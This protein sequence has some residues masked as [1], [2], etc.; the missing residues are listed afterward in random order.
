LIAIWDL[1]R[2]QYL[3]IPCPYRIRC[4]NVFHDFV[5]QH[6]QH[7]R[8]GDYA[9]D[10]YAKDTN[11]FTASMGWR[12]DL[13]YVPLGSARSVSYSQNMSKRMSLYLRGLIFLVVFSCVTILAPLALA[14]DPA[15]KIRLAYAGWEL[16]TARRFRLGITCRPES[17]RC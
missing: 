8:F 9:E 4:K 13:G 10:R 3:F 14:A 16:G 1:R 11:K 15:K 17:R 12:A 7:S 6:L 5:A 2:R